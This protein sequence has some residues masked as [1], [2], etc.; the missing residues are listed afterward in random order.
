MSVTVSLLKLV[1]TR[2]TRAL[3]PEQFAGLVGQLEDE[4]KNRAQWGVVADWLDENEEPGLADGFRWV[5]K[6][7]EVQASRDRFGAWSFRALPRPLN[8]MDF[9][10]RD[11]ATVPGLVAGLVELLRVVRAV[12]T[13]ETDTN[14]EPKGDRE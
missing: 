4:P 5:S 3:W 7:P 11:N 10:E 9:P 14:T 13:T 1:A 12:V 8:L 2:G 6:R